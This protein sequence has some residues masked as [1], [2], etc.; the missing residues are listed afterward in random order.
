MTGAGD[1]LRESVGLFR[2]FFSAYPWRSTMMLAALTAAALAE[3]VGIATLLPLIGIVIDADAVDGVLTRQVEQLFGLL[4]MK[5]SL[6]AVLVVIVSA[7]T[8]KSLLMLLAMAQ[9]GYAAAHAAM[10]LRLAFVR[11]L[12]RAQW[13]HVVAWKAGELASAVSVEPGRA[14]HAYVAACRFLSGGIQLV[15]YLTLAVAISWE[16][17][18]AALVVGSLGVAVLN[19]LVTI[20]RRAGEH[21][22]HLQKSFMI[23]LLQTLDG[24][25]PLKAMAMEESVKPPIEADV[26]NLNKALRVIVVSRETL[27]ES[28]EFIRALAVAGGL[29][30]F[31]AVWSQPVDG[32]LVLA[33]LFARTL[34]RTSQLQ[35]QYQAVAENKS[36]F[37]F[38]R[39]TIAAAEQAREP[40]LG[41]TAPRLTSAISLRDVRFSYGQGYVLDDVSMAMPAG[42]FVAVVGPS[43]S[44]KTTV[45]DLVIGL[46]RPQRG[47]V[48]I[49]DLPMREVDAKAWRDMIGYVPQETSL[50]HDTIMANIVLGNPDIPRTD[51]ESALR[52]A[53]AWDFVAALPDGMDTVVGE[54]GA[55]LSGGQ[56]QRI[57]I[58][59]ALIRNPALLILDEATT[60]LDPETEAE[61]VATIRQL[62]GKLTVLSISHQPA[63]QRAA[64]IVYRLDKGGA[65]LDGSDAPIPTPGTTGAVPST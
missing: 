56:R 25:K 31:V 15:V 33:L 27:A 57:A 52:R 18:L 28:H 1:N 47:E 6:G 62:A 21:Q 30:L 42:S 61:I 2:Y 8:L 14:A 51:V 45:A 11:A 41:G 59:R 3:G 10:D 5:L 29:Y 17:V 36:A 19:R 24:M 58:A 26:R 39:S 35:A 37:A 34:Q 48:W 22:T 54:R 43:G 55:R 32:L 13:M 53:E 44:G 7:L 16:I 65:T 50:F 64:D 46:L 23:R 40:G 49:D 4:G 60:A 38:V 12:L 20:S 63:M 9:V